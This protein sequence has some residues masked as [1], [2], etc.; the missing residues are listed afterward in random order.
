M[1]EKELK[2]KKS[3]SSKEVWLALFI[4]IIIVV[5]VSM[6]LSLLGN[7]LQN[8]FGVNYAY[9]ATATTEQVAKPAYKALRVEQ[10]PI[11]PLKLKAGEEATF[12]VKFK[13]IGAQKWLGKNIDKPVSL[14]MINGENSDFYAKEWLSQNEA[15][16]VKYY[17]DPNVV[18]TFKFKVKAP[19]IN[20]PYSNKLSLFA[21]KDPIPG[22]TIEIIMNVY[23]GKNPSP[24]PPPIANEQIN[25]S[26]TP[27]FWQVISS[28]QSIPE[29]LRFTEPTLRVALFF[30]D[31]K[32]Q[33]KYLPIK[34]Q[35]LDNAPYEIRDKNN[36]LLVNATSGDLL[37]INFDFNL[38]RYFINSNGQ[39]LLM[40]D[41]LLRFLPRDENTIFKIV[42]W[43]NGPFWGM[44][45]N[46][47][48]FRGLIEVQYNPNTERCWLINELPMEKYLKSVSEVSDSSPYELLKA[49]KIAAR[50]Y[51][52][53]RYLNPKYT[54]TPDEE[55]IFT[56]KATQAD[57]VYRGYNF[58]KRAP[59][60]G[61]AAEETRGQVILYNNDPIV[62]YY[63]AQSDGRTRSSYDVRMTTAPVP[64]LIAKNDPPGVGKKLLGHGVG[65]PQR[66]A[67][68]AAQQG[69]NYLQILKYY[70]TG[71]DIKKVYPVK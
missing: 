42:S 28:D 15:Y 2:N 69:A 61:R 66:S 24:P 20:G 51:A 32:D 19:D 53:F 41:Q 70:Y 4:A 11:E 21:G 14:K 58:E 62:A 10:N 26:P 50:T 27:Y 33:E 6:L 1:E 56:L 25:N 9:A 16:R 64:Y 68:V 38:K 47:N 44:P 40:T 59:N 54:D 35:T 22:G 30:A 39:R 34:I 31:T 52:I 17:V 29:D 13:N 36:N 55:P 48:E 12:I 7:F 65:M 3:H 46:D 23:G 67:I 49:Q 45:V 71:V 43:N 5:I 63:F 57:Q 60:I 37:E 18:G 8:K